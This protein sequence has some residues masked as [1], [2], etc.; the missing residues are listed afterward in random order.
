MTNPFYTATGAPVQESRGTSPAVRN[1]F[2]LLQTAFDEVFEA[3]DVGAASGTSTDSLTVGTG[4]KS[5]TIQT[6]RAF[7][8]GQ[9][10]VLA[11]NTTPTTQMTGTI[12]S[13][14]S[15]TGAVVMNVTGTNGSGT[16]AD[17]TLS[18]SPG[19]ALQTSLAYEA[20][21]ANAQIVSGDRSKLIDITTAGF[22]QTFDTPANLNATFGWFTEYRNS[23]TGIVTIP[24][25]DGLTNWVMYPGEHRRFYIDPTGPTLK[26]YIIKPFNYTF[27]SSGNFIMPPGYSGDVDA[28]GF[29]GGGGGGSGARGTGTENGGAGGGGG[30]ARKTQRLTGLVAGTTY[31]VT[32]GAAGA[33][34]AA[35]AVNNT[36]GSNGT[37]GGN[38]T[39]GSLFTAFGGSRGSGGPLSA[40]AGQGGGGSGWASTTNSIT[41][42]QP[43]FGAGGDGGPEGFGGGSGASTAA[44]GQSAFNGGGGG[45]GGS[46]GATAAGAGGSS[47]Y[48]G[49]AGGGGGGIDAGTTLYQP[50]AGG[51]VNTMTAGGGGAA[52]TSHA[53]TPT[54]G[55]AG[56]AG[57]N[58]T[59][60]TGGGGG[61]SSTGA[62]GGAGGAGGFPG[63]GGGGGGSVRNGF[64]S[65]AGGAGGAGMLNLKGVP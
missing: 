44:A 28:I 52:G 45:G 51:N 15:T 34:A 3:I 33:G 7:S 58:G 35:I 60:G 32:I 37:S 59:G 38:T 57:T 24:A 31:P 13:Y 46:D 26:S 53:T 18:L 16:Y 8:P 50:S 27:T 19:N 6:G 14:N 11:Y 12:T 64:N 21:T 56:A 9:S 40:G 25:S 43:G 36:A 23:S 2:A 61:G 4:S 10:V 41:G 65:G 49:A 62:N 22:T 55:T 29:G 1:E 54:S 30:A 47:Y 17:W 48:G 63:G 20:R 42:G 39:L 5:F